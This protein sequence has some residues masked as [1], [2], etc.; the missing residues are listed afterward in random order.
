MSAEP[1]P[2][3]RIRSHQMVREAVGRQLFRVFALCAVS[4]AAGVWMGQH[5]VRL[6]LQTHEVVVSQLQREIRGLT[7]DIQRLELAAA[8]SHQRFDESLN[9]IRQLQ[10]SELRAELSASQRGTQD[11]ERQVEQ[12]L[13]LTDL[14]RN[15]CLS[16]FEVY[17]RKRLAVPAELVDDAIE[18]LAAAQTQQHEQILDT[19]RAQAASAETRLATL[20]D[21]QLLSQGVR[22]SRPTDNTPSLTTTVEA[23]LRQRTPEPALPD[24]RGLPHP[25]SAATEAAEALL[26]ASPSDDPGIEVTIQQSARDNQVPELQPA[27][28]IVAGATT[29]STSAAIASTD[30]GSVISVAQECVPV[31]DAMRL[32]PI[33]ELLLPAAPPE[34]LTRRTPVRRFAAMSFS[35]GRRV[36]MPAETT[37]VATQPDTLPANG[38]TAPQ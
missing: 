10:G 22:S 6:Q 29:G 38:E 25:V 7:G 3:R 4:L 34:V 19:V 33:A 9:E 24:P 17:R 28:V 23:F 26:S 36:A 8:Q 20:G 35:S 13:S 32:E 12:H 31:T 16:E 18:R 11:L 27:V 15:A 30:Q 5:Y 1:K 2:A 14:L 37:S 21:T